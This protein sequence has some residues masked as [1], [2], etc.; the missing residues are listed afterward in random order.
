MSDACETDGAVNDFESILSKLEE[1]VK[2][3]KAIMD[4]SIPPKPLIGMVGEIYLRT[5]VESNQDII[6]VLEQYGG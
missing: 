5:H 6:R 2:E 1:V 3:G 4:P